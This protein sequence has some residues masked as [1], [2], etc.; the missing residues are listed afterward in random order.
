MKGVGPDQRYDPR[1]P[2]IQCGRVVPVLQES[3]DLRSVN[4]FHHLP[5]AHRKIV[6]QHPLRTFVPVWQLELSQGVL[7][8]DKV[9]V[10][11]LARLHELHG[12]VVC[13]SQKTAIR[14]QPPD[15]GLRVV[16]Y[17]AREQ[18]HVAD[19]AC[20]RTRLSA[21]QVAHG[22]KLYKPAQLK[23][24]GDGGEKQTLPG[25]MVKGIPCLA[26]RSLVE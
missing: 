25:S 19:N 8:A 2:C 13:I 6:V 10:G 20:R 5:A 12:N 11:R 24:S 14:H 22:L 4:L 16:L 17:L 1:H 7:K 21:L 15:G 9:L 18:K 23:E 3:R 26:L